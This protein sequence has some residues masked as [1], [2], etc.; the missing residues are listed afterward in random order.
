MNWKIPELTGRLA[1][2]A[3]FIMVTSIVSYGQ[4][5]GNM[6][7]TGYLGVVGGIGSHASFGGS[8]GAPVADRL[9]LSGDLSYIPLGSGRVTVLGST[10]R[11]S[12]SA[13]NFNGNLQYEF[14]P[15]HSVVPYAGGGLG[16]LRSSFDSSSSAL[17][18]G[19]LNVGGSATDMYVNFGGGFRHYVKSRWGFRPE[20]SV[21]AGSNTY[22]RF[23]VGTFYQFGE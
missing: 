9:I 13:I 17:P 18:N 11:T 2:M 6:E 4:N 22:V 5:T 19:S 8:V 14:K 12:A 15:Y 3:A 23:A 7:V 16:F 1:V 10:M 20:F 21:F